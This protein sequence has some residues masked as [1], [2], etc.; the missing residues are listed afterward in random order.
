[1][2]HGGGCV[3]TAPD[4]STL[5]AFADPFPVTTCT[6]H[7]ELRLLPLPEGYTADMLQQ[8]EAELRDPTGI[9]LSPPPVG[10]KMEGIALLDDCGLAYGLDKGNGLE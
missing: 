5:D 6:L 10:I 9:T 3:Q 8:Y 4:F 1:M 7:L 2:A